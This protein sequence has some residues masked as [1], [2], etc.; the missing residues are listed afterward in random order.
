MH[1][2]QKADNKAMDNASQ[3]ER[4]KLINVNG[5]KAKTKYIAKRSSDKNDNMNNEETKKS[6]PKRQKKVGNEEIELK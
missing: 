6:N 5:G 3:E 4:N 2:A 1:M